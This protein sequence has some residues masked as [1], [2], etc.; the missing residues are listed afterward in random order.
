M[1]VIVTFFQ[2]RDR[3][4]MACTRGR[5]DK[6]FLER[7]R[8]APSG[9]IYVRA[10]YSLPLSVMACLDDVADDVLSTIVAF[11]D[12][13][14]RFACVAASRAMRAAVAKLSPRLEHTLEYPRGLDVP[15]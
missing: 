13:P 6:R 14:M 12:L 1:E 15:R 5:P 8:G 11:A 4:P 2:K 9:A 3:L 7:R 10:K